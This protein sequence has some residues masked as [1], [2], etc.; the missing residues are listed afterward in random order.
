MSRRNG[1]RKDAD[2]S[3]KN[4]P[5]YK[6]SIVKIVNSKTFNEKLLNLADSDSVVKEIGIEFV[7]VNS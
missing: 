1:S 4:S 3:W 5:R 2:S 6:Y 7:I